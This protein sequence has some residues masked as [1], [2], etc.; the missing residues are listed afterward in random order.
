M[1]T[2]TGHLNNTYS[3]GAA[4]SGSWN[5]HF[6]LGDTADEFL[7]SQFRNKCQLSQSTWML[8]H[9]QWPGPPFPTEALLYRKIC[10][11]GLATNL[12]FWIAMQNWKGRPL[13]TKA[14]TRTWAA[15][16][17]GQQLC[18]KQDFQSKGEWCSLVGTWTPRRLGS[19]GSG[20]MNRS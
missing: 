11:L 9:L 17:R 1:S 14:G 5:R 2:C 18:V 4:I 20:K 8:I 3:L 12:S 16:G 6:P 19:R 13:S 15:P 7:L 10:L